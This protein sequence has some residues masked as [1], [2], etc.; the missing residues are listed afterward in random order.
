M[1]SDCCQAEAYTA[2]DRTGDGFTYCVRCHERCDTTT[3]FAP[4]PST[5]PPGRRPPVEV[6]AHSLPG[7]R[8]ARTLHDRVAHADLYPRNPA[9]NV[10]NVVPLGTHNN[11]AAPP[12]APGEAA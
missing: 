7:R 2:H 3:T 1:F 12:V 9:S 6:Q 5:S 11:K 8:G 4:R 10:E